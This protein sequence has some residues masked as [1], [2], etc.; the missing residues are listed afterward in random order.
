MQLPANNRIIA[1][2]FLICILSTQTE[3][4]VENDEN[5]IDR[6][7]QTDFR[8]RGALLPPPCSDGVFLRRVSLDVTGR[9]PGAEESRR[10]LKDPS[11][12]KRTVLIDRLLADPAA[13]DYAAMR[14]FDLLRVKSEFPCNLWPNA[15]QAYSR[16]IHTA[17]RDNQPYDAFAR[18]LLIASGSNFRD[19]AVNFYRALPTK[20]PETAATFTAQIFFGSRLET[21]KPADRQ[22]FQLLFTK[23]G[24]RP[25]QEWK[26]EMVFFDHDRPWPGQSS[27]TLAIRMPDGSSV[28]VPPD[29]DP[30]IP[31]ATW[32][33]ARDN[34]FFARCA[35]NRTWFWLMGRGI[36][37]EADDMRP[38]NPPDN[39][40]LLDHL[41]RVLT[42]ARF[43]TRVLCRAILTSHTWQA[44][45][46]DSA[47][48]L[49]EV[50]YGCYVIRQLEAEVLEDLLARLTGVT[51]SYT[52]QV[53]EPFTFTPLGEQTV[54]LGDGSITSPFLEAFGRPSRDTGLLRERVCE[55]NPEQRILLLN[56]ARIQKRITATLAARFIPKP[57]TGKK[58]AA[59][60]DPV[61]QTIDR[62]Y[63]E[64]LARLPTETERRTAEA[65]LRKPGLS[66]QE[67]C[68]DLVWALVNSTNF[69]FKY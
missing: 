37:H 66:L 24:Y 9:L 3:A 35:A 20:T 4:A 21:W 43:D 58:S 39:P 68:R 30:R 23:I 31:F 11:P 26:E 49:P 50:A 40:E 55:P 6:I 17:M 16:W 67:S 61:P 53:P 41:A 2:F 1:G 54:L 63:L 42:E 64:L 46:L 15:V 29:T 22:S 18:E 56:A 65:Y 5:P 47:E 19:P 27:G 32:L 51:E 59:P 13:A 10:F 38:D 62:V 14:W 34:P 28:I 45:A 12:N 8:R 52:S 44:E 25:T 36:V 33:T 7:V 60:F 69:L 48:R 57:P